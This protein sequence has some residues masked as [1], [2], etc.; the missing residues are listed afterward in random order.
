D[1]IP[2]TLGGGSNESE[3]YFQEFT[4][5]VIGEA[6][7]MMVEVFP[8]GAYNDGSQIISGISTDETVIRLITEHDFQLRHTNTGAIVTGVLY[9]A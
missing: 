3:I 6:L 1:Q 2:N 4:E 8:G 7:G 5:A 9:G